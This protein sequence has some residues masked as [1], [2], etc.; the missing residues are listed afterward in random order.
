M[1]NTNDLIK[2]LISKIET[3]DSNMK[4]EFASVNKRL[5]LIDYELKE[6]N[7]VTKYKETYRNIPA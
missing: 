7:T 4:K 3:L 6:L 2:E 5:D 1:E